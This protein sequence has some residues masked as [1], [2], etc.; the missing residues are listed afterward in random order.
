[1]WYCGTAAP[2][3]RGIVELWHRGIV[4]APHSTTVPCSFASRWSVQRLSLLNNFQSCHQF[5]S[6]QSIQTNSDIS[7]CSETVPHLFASRCL[8]ALLC[9]PRFP[10]S[11]I[12]DRV[13]NSSSYQLHVSCKDHVPVFERGTTCIQTSIFLCTTVFFFV[14]NVY[15]HH[16]PCGSRMY[17]K[18]SCDG[19]ESVKCPMQKL[20]GQHGT[21]WLWIQLFCKSD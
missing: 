17:A 19:A 8:S 14:L 1:M 13:T 2:W 11:I 9:I 20:Q 12:W 10:S 18:A 7:P 16:S 3:H 5:L 21:P 15:E 4:E 6:Y